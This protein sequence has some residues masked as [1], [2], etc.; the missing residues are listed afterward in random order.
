MRIPTAASTT[1]EIIEGS[2]RLKPLVVERRVA[3]IRLKEE[4]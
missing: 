4:E 2:P 1:L 3:G